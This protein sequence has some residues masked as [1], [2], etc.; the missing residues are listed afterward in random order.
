MNAPTHESQSLVMADTSHHS[1]MRLLTWVCDWL[2]PELIVEWGPGLS[3]EVMAHHCPEA[4]IHTYEHDETWFKRASQRL[5][6]FR[7]VRLYHR[8]VSLA[9]GESAGYVTSPL[10]DVG[11]SSFDLAF[12][13]GRMRC[14]C[15]TFAWFLLRPGGVAVLH[16]AERVAYRPVLALY[17]PRV[18][19]RAPPPTVAL[20]KGPGA[21]PHPLPIW[22]EEADP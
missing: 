6:D 1:F 18:M 2:H 11:L 14:D 12:V 16:D 10:R 8:K 13:D 7:N 17:S 15:L 20:L 3:T 4:L 5:R 9:P 21:F 22:A 19:D